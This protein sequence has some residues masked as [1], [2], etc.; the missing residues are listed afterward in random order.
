MDGFV[1]EG[2]DGT[3]LLQVTTNILYHHTMASLA[4][5]PLKQKRCGM[6]ASQMQGGGKDCKVIGIRICNFVQ[7]Y[8]YGELGF[9]GSN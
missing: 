1:V 4:C 6:H 7:R 5:Y 8:S 2:W 3:Q 9:M